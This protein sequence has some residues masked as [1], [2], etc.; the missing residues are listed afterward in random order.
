[1]MA[2]IRLCM[3]LISASAVSAAAGPVTPNATAGVRDV[4]EYITALPARAGG[5]VLI[6]QFTAFPLYARYEWKLTVETLHDAAGKWPAILGL[7]YGAARR[8]PKDLD[9][10]ETNR[11]AIDYWRAGGLVTISWH[12]RN[13]WT[14]SHSWDVSGGSLADLLD[15]AMPAHAAWMKSLV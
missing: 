12:A 3:A 13:P 1:M 10:G 11:L 5:R 8:D 4:L 14:G 6:G 15:E 2:T 7:D 9:L